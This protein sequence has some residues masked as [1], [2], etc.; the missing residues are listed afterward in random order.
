MPGIKVVKGRIYLRKRGM[1]N[2]IELKEEFNSLSFHLQADAGWRISEGDP[3]R[4]TNR[5]TAT[6]FLTSSGPK[7][8]RVKPTLSSGESNLTMTGL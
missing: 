7:G 6:G 2:R 8:P 4:A 1:Y 3:G 5:V